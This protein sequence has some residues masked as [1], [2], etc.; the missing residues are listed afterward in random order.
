MATNK[1]AARRGG[2]PPKTMEMDWAPS[3]QA[4]NKHLRTRPLL[5]STRQ[6]EVRHTKKKLAPRPGGRRDDVR[7]H[8]GTGG[9]I[10]PGPR[11]LDSLCWRPILKL[12][13]ILLMKLRGKKR[14]IPIPRI[15]R[16]QVKRPKQSKIGSFSAVPVDQLRFL[17]CCSRRHA[18]WVARNSCE[19]STTPT[20]VVI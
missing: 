20:P 1:T 4:C 10:G 13:I 5:E 15:K 11:C 2:N 19:N 8:M 17:C 6:E 18:L 12:Y 3:S 16:C 9:E 14:C 7:P